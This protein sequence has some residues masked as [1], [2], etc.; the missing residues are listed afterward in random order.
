MLS[1]T[2]FLCFQ[3]EHLEAEAVFCP[4]MNKEFK[5]ETRHE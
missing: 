2:L 1:M 3:C 5:R 4:W